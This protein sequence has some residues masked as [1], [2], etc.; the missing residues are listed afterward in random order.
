MTSFFKIKRKRIQIYVRLDFEKAGH[1]Q[2]C[3]IFKWNDYITRSKR[4]PPKATKKIYK[5]LREL[6]TASF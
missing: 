2:H 6:R 3:P 5:K 4:S 1:S